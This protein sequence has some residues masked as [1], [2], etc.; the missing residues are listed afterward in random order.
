MIEV[1]GL[2]RYYGRDA[3]VQ[4]VSFT[5]S[6]HEIVG[7]LGLNG[8]GKSTTLKI[9]AGLL[10][11]SSGSVKIDGVDV[12]QATDDFR[13]NIGFLPEDTPLY[14]D[15][16]VGDFVAYAGQ[17]KGMPS[18]DVQARLDDV[19]RR[20]GLTD[21]KHQVISELSHG[22]RKRV[23]IAQAIIH[24]PKLVIL[25]EPISGLD[26]KQIREIREVVVG[27]KESC[28][29]LIS[30]HI[31]SE[32]SQTCDRIL[33]LKDGRLVAEGSEDE[34][35]ASTAGGGRF[36]LE[37]RGNRSDV[38]RV[39]GSFAGAVSH[40]VTGES[41]G[42]VSVTII[43]TSDAREQLVAHIVAGGLGLRRLDESASELEEIFLS[44]TS[45]TLGGAA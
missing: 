37:V 9:L 45:T 13:S 41:A 33:V 12:V 16:R 25:D 10:L 28:T 29:V 32:I 15:M 19:L 17:L 36:D 24:D 20:C 3:A 26:P 42:V 44:L 23:G 38:D 14:K 35:A 4:D 11:P 6:D 5:I 40:E 18:A 21:R 30:S 8:A 2:T 7:F 1:A 31:L 22:Y 27:L 34:L 43:L 39:L